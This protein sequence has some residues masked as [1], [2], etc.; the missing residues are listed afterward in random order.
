[1]EGDL[2]NQFPVTRK[3][4]GDACASRL[5]LSE[6]EPCCHA[7]LTGLEKLRANRLPRIRRIC[8]FDILFAALV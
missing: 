6:G 5:W 4:S 2:G 3:V 8:H 1:V 7:V